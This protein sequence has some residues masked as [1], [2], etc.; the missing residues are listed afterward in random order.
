M[1]CAA[2]YKYETEDLHS[3]FAGFVMVVHIHV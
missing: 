3:S 2:P 1:V